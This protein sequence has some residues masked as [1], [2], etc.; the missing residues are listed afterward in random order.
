MNASRRVARDLNLGAANRHLLGVN[1]FHAAQMLG[2][3]TQAQNMCGAVFYPQSRQE[4]PIPLKGTGSS[5]R[6]IFIPDHNLIAEIIKII[7]RIKV[8]YVSKFLETC[9]LSHKP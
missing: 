7:S 8:Q 9:S 5:C 6:Q 4:E 2:P 3:G 1:T